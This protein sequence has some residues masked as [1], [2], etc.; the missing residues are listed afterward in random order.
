M[1]LGEARVCRAAKREAGLAA[2]NTAGPIRPSRGVAW[3]GMGHPTAVQ[4]GGLRWRFEYGSLWA[5]LKPEDWLRAP[6]ESWEQRDKARLRVK[7][8]PARQAMLEMRV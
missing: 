6:R 2:V 7:S 5:V 3:E 4:R 1:G 8:L